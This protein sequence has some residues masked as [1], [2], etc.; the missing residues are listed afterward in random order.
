MKLLGRIETFRGGRGTS[1]PSAHYGGGDRAAEGAFSL[2]PP[3]TAGKP[4]TFLIE[5]I[6]ILALC[7]IGDVTGKN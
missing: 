1:N 3:K 2:K 4:C 7:K 5:N 6:W